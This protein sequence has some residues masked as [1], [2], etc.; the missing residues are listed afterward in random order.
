MSEKPVSIGKITLGIAHGS[1]NPVAAFQD[2]VDVIRDVLG[3]IPAPAATEFELIDRKV[4]RIRAITG[5][6]LN[7]QRP[8]GYSTHA[9]GVSL[10]EVVEDCLGLVG[11]VI[12]RGDVDVETEFAVRPV[13]RADAGEIRRVS[14]R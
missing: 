13:V 2:N 9:G 6:R 4:T 11:R 7:L 3:P 1:T 14:S 12:A 10:R 5:K 8:S